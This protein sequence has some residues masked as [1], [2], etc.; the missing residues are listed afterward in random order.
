MTPLSS[1]QWRID[2]I[3]WFILNTANV[4]QK[5]SEW[6]S[7]AQVLN[8]F[9]ASGSVVSQVKN[10]WVHQE[11]SRPR[12]LSV[13]VVWQCLLW[14]FHQVRIL[15]SWSKQSLKSRMVFWNKKGSGWPMVNHSGL[16]NQWFRR[17]RGKT[18]KNFFLAL[19]GQR[20]SIS[21]FVASWFMEIC[22]ESVIPFIKITA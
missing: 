19:W 12:M 5:D 1:T 17:E 16:K 9:A 2:P 3:S 4:Y 22:Q 15:F 6:D 10:L 20:V 18:L 21:L 7:G 14:E 11:W 8:C 13:Q